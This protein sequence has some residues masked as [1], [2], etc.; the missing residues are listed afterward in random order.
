MK[1]GK[2]IFLSSMLLI[3]LAFGLTGCS[4]TSHQQAGENS[5][6]LKVICDSQDI[7]QIFYTYYVDGVSCGMGGMADLEGGEITPET[8]LTVVFP[9][10]YFEENPDISKFSIDFS[11]YGKDDQSEI[12][13]TAPVS[14]EAEYGNTYTVRFSGDREQGFQAH[15]EVP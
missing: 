3:L 8:D 7:Y 15:L 5:F 13:T 6:S 1:G 14:I 12:A 10:A 2:R 11:P 4:Q 9:E